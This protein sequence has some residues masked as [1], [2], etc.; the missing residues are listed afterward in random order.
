MSVEDNSQEIEVDGEMIDINEDIFNK[1]I[2]KKKSREQT[3]VKKKKK[4]VKPKPPK[5]TFNVP[6]EDLLRRDAEETKR[7]RKRPRYFTDFEI[8]DYNNDI[9]TLDEKDSEYQVKRQMMDK[10]RW[11]EFKKDDNDELPDD[12]LFPF[13][14]KQYKTIRNQKG[15][16]KKS[17]K[18]CLLRRMKVQVTKSTM[19]TNS[20]NFTY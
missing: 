7:T 3:Q 19:N 20:P 2:R 16:K 14:T 13:V 6:Q 1:Q 17:K 5:I 4:Q 10:L 12:T 11:T 15:K 8:P 18:A 9:N